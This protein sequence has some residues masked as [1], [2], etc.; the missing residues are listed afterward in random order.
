MSN[1]ATEL[2]RAVNKLR[3]KYR[4]YIVEYDIK[5]AGVFIFR[6]MLSV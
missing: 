1:P 4:S 3:T 6:F 2:D 5:D